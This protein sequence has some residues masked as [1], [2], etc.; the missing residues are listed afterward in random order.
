MRK[1]SMEY[2]EQ[3]LA[4]IAE[5]DEINADLEKRGGLDTLTL[6]EQEA[7]LKLQ[8]DLANQMTE[9]L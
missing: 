9:V 5:L 7:V 3:D 2:T 6:E 8:S 4:I 1:V